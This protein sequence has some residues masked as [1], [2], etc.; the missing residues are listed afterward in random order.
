[1]TTL[2]SPGT[3]VTIL[4]EDFYIGGNTGTTPLLFIATADEKTQTDGITPAL[5]TYEYGVLRT[6]TSLKQ[7]VDLY[8]PAVFRVSADGQPHHGDSRNEYG[9]DALA[10]VLE[11][12]NRAY[13]IRANINLND[14]L[15]DIK[16]LWERKIAEAGDYLNSLVADWIAQYNALNNY[17]QADAGYKTSVPGATLKTLIREALTDAFLSYSFSEDN[18]EVAYLT[19]HTVAQA[20]YHDVLFATGA[21]F[22]Q[23]T[24]ITGL[25]PTGLYGARVT[26]VAAPATLTGVVATSTVGSAIATVTS[27]VGI[28]VGDAVTVT[29]GTMTLSGSATV[30]SVDSLT[31]I[32][33]SH[34]FA[35]TGTSATLTF[36][37]SGTVTHNINLTGSQAQTY[38]Q[39]VTVINGVLG[40]SGTA[41]ILQGRLRIKSSLTGATSS[42]EILT[43]AISGRQPLFPSLNL[44]SQLAVK[45]QGKGVTSLDV[46]DADYATITGGYDGL[47]SLV[48]DWSTGS[49][50]GAPTEFTSSEAEGLLLSSATTFAATKEFKD[51]V[52]LGPNDAARRAEIVRALQAAVNDPYSRARDEGLEYN[53]VIA[54][55][56][57][58][59]ADELLRL[60]NDMFDEIFV[61]GETPFDK[62]PVGPNS[63]SNWAV[64]V[65]RATSDNIAYWYGHG[66]SSN[67]TGEDILS[68][69]GTTALRVLAYSDANSEGEWIAPAGPTR[70]VCPHLTDVGYVSGTLGGPTTFVRNWLDNGTRDDLYEFP[71]NINPITFIPGRG[72]LVMGQKTTS[73]IAKATDRI[74]VSR[75]VKY[76]KRQL[77]KALFSYLFE[78][79]DEI[80]RRNVKA[81]VD[82]FLASLIDRRALY[83]FASIC[84]EDNNT[85]QTIDANE[86]HIDIAI[87][88]VKAVEFIYARVRIVRTGADIG[89]SK[90]IN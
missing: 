76:I 35:G 16:D 58:E 2:I 41:S 60:G 27:T 49:T 79:N 87:K 47:H 86:L 90:T 67:L 39:L 19:D 89:T 34:N 72:L 71:K 17:V 3:D 63:I 83:D 65:G 21:G 55:G 7:A 15:E 69:A 84:D 25:E 68:S 6:V 18:F 57:P 54:P 31:Q 82:N 5:G 45:V 64:G 28:N 42:V 46:Y 88:P 70:G 66:I 20:G 4:N 56:Y 12:N 61:I 78:P 85:P 43:G 77:R 23:G 33:L 52:S 75:L 29:A 11:V 44:Y 62:P 22:I 8:G 26:T 59:L 36:T 24:D 50:A 30:L 51:S 74:N 37:G 14:N 13:V 38:S 1:M 48:D 9:L 80:T 81:S 53:I 32:T 73:P 10:K 40:S